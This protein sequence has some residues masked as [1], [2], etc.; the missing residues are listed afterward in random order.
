MS[1]SEPFDEQPRIQLKLEVVRGGG[2]AGRKTAIALADYSDAD[3]DL[4]TVPHW[5]RIIAAWHCRWWRN[6]LRFRTAGLI[7]EVMHAAEVPSAVRV[8]TYWRW[9]LWCA[10]TISPTNLAAVVSFANRFKSKAIDGE[11]DLRVDDDDGMD[12]LIV[13]A[14]QARVALRY[15]LKKIQYRSALNEAE[16]VAAW[17]LH[18][19]IGL[20]PTQRWFRKSQAQEE[21]TCGSS[22]Q[23]A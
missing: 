12:E 17:L 14:N 13:H 6:F 16:I 21:S 11:L 2:G 10:E 9:G 18:R 22:G 8:L 5:F 7:D 4:P 1:I 15:A 19:N 20:S 23:R 3:Y